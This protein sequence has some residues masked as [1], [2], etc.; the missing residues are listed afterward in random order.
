V[1]VKMVDSIKNIPNVQMA[2]RCY[3]FQ[4][5][6]AEHNC[7]DSKLVV[8][9]GKG[10]ANDIIDFVKKVEPKG[11][12]PIAYSLEQSAEDFPAGNGKNII[13]LITDGI[14]E[15]D[16]DPCAVSKQL[17]V[18]NIIL[19]PYIIG[20]GMT[21]ETMKFFDCVGKYY[22]PKN[23][24]EFADIFS[25]IVSKT[26][27]NTGVVVQLM[28]SKGQPM[29]TN[30]E[31]AFINSKT[32]KADYNMYHTMVDGKADTFNI[33]PGMYDLHLH[34]T[35]PVSKTNVQILP[36]KINVIK[37]DAPT[38]YLTVNIN[39][40]K[41]YSDIPCVVR[42]SGRPET[43]YVQDMGTKHRFLTGSYD[44]EFLTL[45]RKTLRNVQVRQSETNSITFPEPGQMEAIY[46]L[47]VVGAVFYMHDNKLEWLTD[48][49]GN[50]NS[51]RELIQL[52]PGSYHVIY[53]SATSNNTTDT[54]DKAFVIT[55]GGKTPVKI[56]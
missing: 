28:D 51:N 41:D 42:K 27:D 36:G 23:E 40:T 43:V 24:K 9:F 10:N 20:I 2:L 55:S 32:H 16:G 18:K 22:S 21:D 49:N 17:Q 19:K 8:P 13:L 38:G 14:E 52:Q 1:L 44:L 33:S 3:G 47:N 31:M 29:E 5:T 45:P 30:D 4:N 39:S 37:V 12:T 15:C 6:V 7:K 35:P 56:D 53:R 54:K 48:L 34:T 50:S 25:G 46:S 26:L 11:Y